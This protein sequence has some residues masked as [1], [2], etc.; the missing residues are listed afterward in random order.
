MNEVVVGKPEGESP[1][2][3][4]EDNIEFILKSRVGVDWIHQA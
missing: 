1:I 4:W 2:G 3:R